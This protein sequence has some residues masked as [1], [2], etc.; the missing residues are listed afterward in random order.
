MTFAHEFTPRSE[1]DDVVP[2]YEKPAIIAEGKISVR[3]GSTGAETSGTS[4]GTK[5]DIDLFSEPTDD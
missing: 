1:E 4:R 5:D 3:A 2:A